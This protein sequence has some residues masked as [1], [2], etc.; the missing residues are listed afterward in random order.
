MPVQNPSAT[1]QHSPATV[2]VHAGRPAAA[3]GAPVNPSIVLSTT[4]HAA[5]VDEAGH[6]DASVVNYARS[7]VDT[8]TA[9]EDAVG[10]LEHGRATVFGSGM[11]AVSAAVEPLVDAVPDRPARV[12]VGRHGYS[13]T[14]TLLQHLAASGRATVQRVDTADEAALHA[15]LPGADL[16]WLESPANPTMEVVDIAAAVARAGGAR[17]LVDS[18]YATP[19]GQNPLLLGADLVVHSASKAISGHSDVLLGVVVTTDPALH[20][21]VHAHRTRHGAVPGPFEVW[22]ALRGLRTLDVRL[23]R[24]QHNAG[25]LAERLLGHPAVRGVRYPGLAGDPGNAVAQRQMHGA[26]SIL[27]V[28]VADGAAA[29]RLAAG[30]RLWVHATS[31]GG[32]ESLVER[33]RR[34]PA[35]T[36]TVPDG[37][38]RLSVGIEDVEDLWTDLSRA[39]D[40]LL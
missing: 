39:L 3:P 27:A 4:F 34:H 16:V 12:V 14:D 1:P 21:G 9:F 35:E 5:T 11:A 10:A 18:T 26:G 8:W 25:V 32:V 37:L 40:A 7:G 29:E 15:A 30:T 6:A 17:V 22:L 33:R 19:L 23:S 24:A 2:A 31:L 13:G 36:G 20:A 38:L 28:E